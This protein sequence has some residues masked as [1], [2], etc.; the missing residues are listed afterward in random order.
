LPEE[1][2]FVRSDQ[3]SFVRQGIPSTYLKP[4]LQST[5]P[6]IDAEAMFQEH[7][8]NHYHTASD[9]LSRPVDWDS[10]ERFTRAHIRIGQ[11]IA[12]NPKRPTWNDGDFF[13]ERFAR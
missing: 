8:L 12:D 10:V 4:G 3:Y 9:D 7:R 11:A 5:D 13:G 6:A 2:L 1:N